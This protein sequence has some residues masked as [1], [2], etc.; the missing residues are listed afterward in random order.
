MKIIKILK[1]KMEHLDKNNSSNFLKTTDHT[2]QYLKINYRSSSKTE[3]IH[4][5]KF[6]INEKFEKIL[7]KKEKM[8][9]DPFFDKKGSYEFLE[10]KNKALKEFFLTDE[11]NPKLKGGVIYRKNK[12]KRKSG[13]NSVKSFKYKISIDNERKKNNSN[14]KIKYKKFKDFNHLAIFVNSN[15]N[16]EKIFYDKKLKKYKPIKSNKN[17]CSYIETFVSKNSD[18]EKIISELDQKP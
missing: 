7:F 18:L 3:N 10:S 2:E 5:K 8:K 1:L 15:L 11:I 14:S 17:F 12:T 13:K 4:G 16:D 6:Y 9:I